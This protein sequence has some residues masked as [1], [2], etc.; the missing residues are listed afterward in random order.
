MK[1]QCATVLAAASSA[2]AG[3]VWINWKENCKGNSYPFQYPSSQTST[4]CMVVDLP[5]DK[6]PARS[7]TSFVDDGFKCDAFAYSD[8][9]CTSVVL[10]ALNGNQC[11]GNADF[12]SY[13]ITCSSAP[14][15][16]K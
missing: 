10:A 4:P 14:R 8:D 11:A 12:R 13:K 7:I 1:L 15:A 16:K 9:A 5:S 2:L 6:K 3:K